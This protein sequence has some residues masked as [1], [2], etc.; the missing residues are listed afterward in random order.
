ML[1]LCGRYNALMRYINDIIVHSTATPAG[2]EV[3]LAE[4]ESWHKARGWRGCGYHYLI[5]LDGTIDNGAYISQPGTH[6][7]GHNAHSIGVCYVGGVD[8]DYKAEDTRT[9]EQKRALK[10]LVA[11]LVKMY[12][13]QVHGHRD[14]C[15]TECPSFDVHH[16]YDGMVKSILEPKIY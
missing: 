5:H 12:R 11:R 13:C 4:V 6:C 1:Y 9:P 15:P 10:Q 8:K 3:S 2:R 14:Y 7:R 16:E